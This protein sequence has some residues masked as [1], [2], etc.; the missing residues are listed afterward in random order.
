MK[1]KGTPVRKSSRGT[2]RERPDNGTT[3]VSLI[4]KI[5]QNEAN[6]KDN[7]VDAVLEQLKKVKGLKDDLEESIEK[8]FELYKDRLSVD[9][10]Y[11]RLSMEFPADLK[12]VIEENKVDDKELP[13]G[14]CFWIRTCRSM[15]K[16]MEKVINQRNRLMKAQGKLMVKKEQQR[17]QEKEM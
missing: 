1:G 16:R 5:I 10:M 11:S 8:C 7:G 13:G 15:A 4:D 17:Q 2:K 6:V 3:N 12:E 9:T 14:K